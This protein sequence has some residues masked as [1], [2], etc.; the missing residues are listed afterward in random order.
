MPEQTVNRIA[1]TATGL[2]LVAP[3]TLST[4]AIVLLVPVLP[5]L[6]RQFADLPGRDYW[7]P[8]LLTVPALCVA[9]FSPVAGILGDR[10]GRRALLLW[11][12][13]LYG[14]LGTMP[15]YLSDFGA[16]FASRIGVGFTEA[17]LVT[18]STTMIADYFAGEARNRWLAAQTAVASVSATGFFL[19]GGFLGG[20][21]WRAPFL[22]YASAFAMMVVVALF[23]WDVKRPAKTEQRT[24]SSWAD[25]PSAHMSRVVGTTLLGSILFYTLQI[26]V[27]PGLAALGVTAPE[28]IGMLTALVSL[29]VPIGT[30]IYGRMSKESVPALLAIDFAILAAGLLVMGLAHGPTSF[31]AG[32]A[33]AQLGAGMLLPTLLV[34]AVGGV[35]FELRARVTGIWTGAFTLGQFLSP[36]AVTF[37][38]SRVGG[39]QSTFQV[40]S[41]LAL[42]AVG[43]AVAVRVSSSARKSAAN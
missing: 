12:L 6:L 1:G 27:S 8:A 20:F 13:L 11:A 32:C 15:L 7:V 29:G 9:L 14:L 17:V 42:V 4:M 3:I 10:F 19:L 35:P 28:Q 21:S 22:V 16:I 38:T 30:V 25:F 43:V 41:L 18:L 2:A 23:T 33:V 40:L 31:L 37:A 24:S 34:W 26:Q 36:I 5:T 39:L